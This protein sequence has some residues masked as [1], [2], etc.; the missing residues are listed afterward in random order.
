MPDDCYYHNP[1]LTGNDKMTVA[2]LLAKNK[3]KIP[4]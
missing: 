2:M 3:Q 4:K 1:C